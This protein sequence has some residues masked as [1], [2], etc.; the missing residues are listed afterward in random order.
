MFLVRLVA[1]VYPRIRLKRTD[2]SI[3][4]SSISGT[5]SYF[6]FGCIM[7]ININQ[8]KKNSGKRTSYNKGNKRIMKYNNSNKIHQRFYANNII[9][10]KNMRNLALDYKK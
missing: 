9:P 1:G 7:L 3:E 8:N 6:L 2:L 10:R 5:S 4:L